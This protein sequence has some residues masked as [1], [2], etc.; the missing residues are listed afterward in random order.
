MIGA[1]IVFFIGFF[2]S[3]SIIGLILG[4]PLIILSLIILFLGIIIPGKRRVVHVHHHH[5]H[6][7][8]RK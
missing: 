2:L 3:I 7:R 1:L 4:I 5:H 8:K 6:K